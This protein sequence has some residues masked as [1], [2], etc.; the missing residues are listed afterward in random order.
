MAS[1]NTPIM[2]AIPTLEITAIHIDNEP[3]IHVEHLSISKNSKKWGSK[4]E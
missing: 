1:A 3:F 2:E 4:D